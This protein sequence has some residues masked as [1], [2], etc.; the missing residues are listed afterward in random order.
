V[1]RSPSLVM[2]SAQ[3]K[4]SDGAIGTRWTLV[5]FASRPATTSS[6]SSGS[7]EQVQ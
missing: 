6:P 7:S 1:R 2:N 4:T 5:S 3:P